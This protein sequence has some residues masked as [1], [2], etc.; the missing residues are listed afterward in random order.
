ME[1][2]PASWLEA[3]NTIQKMLSLDNTDIESLKG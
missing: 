2:D 3:R 1:L